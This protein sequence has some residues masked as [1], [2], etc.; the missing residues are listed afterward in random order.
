MNNNHKTVQSLWSVLKAHYIKISIRY[1]K[2]K[3]AADYKTE[4]NVM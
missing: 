4:E 2:L 3:I 1:I